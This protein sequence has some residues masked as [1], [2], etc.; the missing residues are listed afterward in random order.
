M[1]EFLEPHGP[2]TPLAPAGPGCS[3]HRSVMLTAMQGVSSWANSLVFGFYL[4]KRPDMKHRVEEWKRA[5]AETNKWRY[6]AALASTLIR[7]S[8]HAAAARRRGLTPWEYG[9]I[10]RAETLLEELPFTTSRTTRLY[11]ISEALEAVAQDFDDDRS[12]LD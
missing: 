12:A 7:T 6:V 4:Q 5:G 11:L 10:K 2:P 3:L 1:R 9:A 8:D